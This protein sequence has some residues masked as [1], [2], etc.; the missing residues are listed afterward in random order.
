MI[1]NLLRIVKLLAFYSWK[2][3]LNF[4][5]E[6]KKN[7]EVFMSPNSTG[8]TGWAFEPEGLLELLYLAKCIHPELFENLD[9]FKESSFL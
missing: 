4:I 2:S 9:M 3:Q 7:N 8:R 1:I 5:W 6:K